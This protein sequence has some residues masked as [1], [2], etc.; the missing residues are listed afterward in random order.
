HQTLSTT[1]KLRIHSR[2]EWISTT[3]QASRTHA[4]DTAGVH[5]TAQAHPP[6]P[7]EQCLAAAAAHPVSRVRAHASTARLRRMAAR[8]EALAMAGGA[9]LDVALRFEAVVVG[10]SAREARLRP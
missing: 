8:A 7:L 1:L 3:G 4:V 2:P 6:R 9:L 10:T 5:M